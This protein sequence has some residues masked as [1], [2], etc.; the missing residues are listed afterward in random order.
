[1]WRIWPMIW[2]LGGDVVAPDGKKVGFDGQPGLRALTLDPSMATQD[3]SRLH[4]QDR[5]SEKMYQVFNSATAWAWCRP[6]RGS[7]PRS[8]RPR[9]TTASSRCRRF[10][11]KP[12][13]ISGPDTW[14]RVR[15]R[16]GPQAR[17]APEFVQV[18]H[19]ARA[20]RASGTSRPAA[21]RCAGPPP[22]RPR[23][24]STST[25]LEGWSTFVDALDNARVRPV[26]R[27]LSED[28]RGA[29]A[30]DRR[31]CCSA[32]SRRTTRS[33]R[34]SSGGNTGAGEAAE[35]RA[36][37]TV[38][39]HG[40]RAPALAGPRRRAP[41][42]CS[43][44]S[45]RRR[46][47]GCTSCPAVRDHRRAG[48]R[49]GRLVA[50]AVRPGQGPDRR[51]DQLRRTR[52]TTGPLP[53]PGVHGRGRPHADLHGAVRAAERRRRARR[54]RCCSTAACASSASTGRSPSCRSWCRRRFRACCSRS[55]S[56]TSSGSRTRCCTARARPAAVLRR[57]RAGAAAARARRAV[58][59]TSCVASARSSIWPRC[60]TSRASWSR[61]PRSTARGRGGVFRHVTLPALRPVTSSCCCGRR[62]RRVQLFDLVYV[63][64]R[65]G[66]AESTDVVVYY[67]YRSIRDSAYGTGAA[68]AYVVAVALLVR[69]ASP[70]S[71][72]LACG[73]GA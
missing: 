59:G 55:S 39:A 14:M 52:R 32:S 73:R 41:R 12:V 68:A 30:G 34:P 49:A 21:C 11:G 20:G 8:S 43:G 13:T 48:D 1:M 2:D 19:P 66:P 9:S 31:A 54:W 40:R 46:A 62:C 3:K 10:D 26:D 18:A 58:G 57:R 53:R 71:R 65:A 24:S 37:S 72:S 69:R 47:R 44:R 7:C 5:G 23:G 61:P 64:T 33:T 29:R 22:R 28:L 4:R 15:Q 42:G 70:A 17:R 51:D 56:T 67:V 38:F 16:R 36:L 27:G 25:E 35:A 63:T 60:R 45:A 6:G 50:A